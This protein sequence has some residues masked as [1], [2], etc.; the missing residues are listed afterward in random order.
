MTNRFYNILSPIMLKIL[1]CLLIIF[2]FASNTILYSQRTTLNKINTIGDSLIKFYF[3]G[4]ITYST[5]LD[6]SK[7]QITLLLNNASLSNSVNNF[8]NVGN[9]KQILSKTRNNNVIVQLNTVEPIGY[10]TFLDQF[11][12]QIY[13]NLFSWKELTQSEDLYHTGLLSLEVGLDSLATV[14]LNQSL[15]MG[16]LKAS[17]VLSINE[18]KLG[19]INRA[20][21]YSEIGEYYTEE[22]PQ[23]LIIRAAILKY[24]GDSA[25]AKIIENRYKQLTGAEII[26]LKIP[27]TRIEGDTLSISEIHLIDSL[28]QILM[29]SK[30]DTL[31]PELS[32]F[33]VL[34][35][36]TSKTKNEKE[37][38]QSF[39]DSIPFWLQL[40]IGGSFAA[41]MLLLYFYFRWR[42]LQ[43]KANMSKTRQKAIEKSQIQKSKT[44]QAVITKVPTATIKQKYS[45]TQ[46]NETTKTETKEK[47][48]IVPITPEKANKIEEAI[49]SIKQE[50]IKEQQDSILEKQTPKQHS[51]AKIEL[52]NNLLN[53]Q[54]RIKQ[55]KIKNIPVDLVSKS[56]KIKSIANELGLEENSLEIKKT[57]DNMLKDQSK[58]EKLSGK[59]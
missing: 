49:K 42:T 53:E 16:Y 37:L 52:A 7:T 3:D 41:I 22:F 30:S 17:N 15:Q 19:R 24:R 56:E 40:V 5:E 2:I 31:N 36:T 8:Q 38:V 11:T 58:I 27:K 33:N 57:V 50:K 12:K 47:E 34:F 4:N 13:L 6:S 25:T 35:D 48:N 45:S 32:R 1:G 26:P 9:I 20:L 39:Y 59:L 55:Q 51:N 46:S 18:F 29:M 54:K 28:A 43:V 44:K 10:T 21:K 23:V 14:Y